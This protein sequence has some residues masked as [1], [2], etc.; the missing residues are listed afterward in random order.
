MRIPKIYMLHF[1]SI[2]FLKTLSF[3]WHNML[4]NY[5]VWLTVEVWK[6]SSVFYWQVVWYKSSSDHLRNQDMNIFPSPSASASAVGIA[7]SMRK[8]KTDFE[9]RCSIFTYWQ[10]I[11]SACCCLIIMTLFAVQ[12][13]LHVA[14]KAWSSKHLA[15]PWTEVTTFM[16]L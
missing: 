8:R 4:L 9:I 14:Y 2:F 1:L 6:F 13:F 7:N 10:N 3:Y 5:S 16:S 15:A 11:A 12:E